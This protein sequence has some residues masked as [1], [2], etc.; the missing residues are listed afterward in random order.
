[1]KDMQAFLG[2]A[3][4]YHYFIYNYSNIATLLI[5][6]TQKKHAL[7]LWLPILQSF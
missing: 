7:E 2:F 1:M 6:L 4:F 3:N 5:W